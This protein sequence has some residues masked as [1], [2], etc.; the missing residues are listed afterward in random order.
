MRGRRLD[1][2][3]V[4]SSFVFIARLVAADGAHFV[5]VIVVLV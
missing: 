4:A 2:L 1:V 3:H 5:I